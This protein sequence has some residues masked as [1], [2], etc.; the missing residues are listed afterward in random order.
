VINYGHS[1]SA[2]TGFCV[3]SQNNQQMNLDLR[4][5]RSEL[6]N[7]DI[8]ILHSFD[9]DVFYLGILPFFEL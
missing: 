9:D 2:T 5:H 7:S 3:A 4:R 8:S 1:I 6:N